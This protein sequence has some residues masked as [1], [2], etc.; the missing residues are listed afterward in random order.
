MS[1]LN[2]AGRAAY[3]GS[4]NKGLTKREQFAAMAMQGLLAAM[5]STDASRIIARN[6]ASNSIEIADALLEGLEAGQ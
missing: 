4:V 6:I 1:E 3:P 2:N 5:T